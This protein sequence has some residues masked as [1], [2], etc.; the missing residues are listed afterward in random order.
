MHHMPK[1]LSCTFLMVV[2]FWKLFITFH[3]SL[4]FKITIME[5]YNNILIYQTYQVTRETMEK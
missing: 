1:I 4:N 5:D 3:Q 2:V